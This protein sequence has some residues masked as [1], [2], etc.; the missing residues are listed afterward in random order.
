MVRTLTLGDGL[1][2]VDLL[3]SGICHIEASKLIF[4]ANPYFYDSAGYLAHMSAELLLK[5]WLLQE[6]QKF[7]AIHNLSELYQELVDAHGAMPL[8]AEHERVLGLLDVYEQLRYP[9][10][11]K[12][13]EVGDGDWPAIE[14]FIHYLYSCLPSSLHDAL[15]QVKPFEKDGRELMRRRIETQT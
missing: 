14:A 9:N 6:A 3:H 12:P 7:K 15:D 1:I 10:R 4:K 13:T 5:A 8:S 11:D 2:P